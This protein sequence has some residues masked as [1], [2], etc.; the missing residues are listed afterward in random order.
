MGSEVREMKVQKPAPCLA[1][2]EPLQ[3]SQLQFRLP[4]KPP[5]AVFKRR[6]SEL[7]C[8]TLHLLVE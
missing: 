4:G 6:V 5:G 1:Q 2:G 8:Y 7:A 3:P